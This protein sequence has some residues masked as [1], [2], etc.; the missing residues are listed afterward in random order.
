[1]TGALQR[2]LL[3]QLRRGG[4][5]RQGARRRGGQEAVGSERDAERPVLSADGHHECIA[6]CPIAPTLSSRKV[7]PP[8]SPSPRFITLQT[9]ST[10][11]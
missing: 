4:N 3:L 7:S 8:L 6:D 11:D 2:P 9:Y 5:E 1:G 10:I